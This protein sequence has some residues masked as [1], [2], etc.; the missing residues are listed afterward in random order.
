MAFELNIPSLVQK[1]KASLNGMKG[2]PNEL[3]ESED[4]F[5]RAFHFQRPFVP[6]WFRNIAYYMG[7]QWMDW[8]HNL[9][10]LTSPQAP[11]WK[12]RL[13]INLIMP[14]I[15]T[16]AAKILRNNP[17]IGVVPSNDS[18]MA[19]QA[20]RIG[21]RVMD[22]KYHDDD[23]QRK[24]YNLVLWMLTCGSAFLWTLWDKTAGKAWS[25]DIRN[26]EDGTIVKKQFFQ[27][28]VVDIVSGP[29]EVLMEPGA[30][31]DFEDHRRIMRI[32]VLDVVFIKDK[33][34]VD[35]PA[36]TIDQHLQFQFRINSFSH[37]NTFGLS[38][39]NTQ[40]LPRNVAL[41]KEIFELPSS[42]WPQGLHAMYANGVVIVPPEP[43]DYWLRGRRVLPVAKYDHITIPGRNYGMSVIEQISPL[44]ILFNKLNS[45]AVENANLLSRPKIIAPQGSLDDDSWT[46]QPGEVVEYRPV[47]GLGPSAMTPPSMPQY[48]FQL[49]DSIP[50]WI[51]DVSGIFDVSKGKLPRRATSG[52]AID[53]LQDADDTRMGLTIRNYASSLERSLGIKLQ[54]IKEN[55]VEERIVKKI[56]MNHGIEIMRFKGADLKDADTVRVMM[57]PALSR[58][59][60]INLGLKLAEQ[61]LV[62]KEMV[63]KIIELG[64]I[65]MIFDQDQDQTNFA[66]IE[67]FMMSKGDILEPQQF[68]PH[69]L[70]IKEHTDFLRKWEGKISK[71][72][73][74]VIQQHME[75]HK[76]MLVA[77]VP[78][79][80]PP[81]GGVPGLPPQGQ[82]GPVV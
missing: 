74:L 71:E 22:G 51:A 37:L 21:T 2:L 67:N 10:F 1:V 12:V 75:I 46:D 7:L 28:D 53:L 73:L 55:Y 80:G 17:S 43:L 63:L 42:K 9:Q 54:L 3:K 35:V 32:Q 77:M 20:A 38:H 62:P 81:D 82:P 14:T 68:E 34:G 60:K 19:R 59:A 5:A 79:G 26:P 76:E 64:D 23:F 78:P 36:E 61:N 30:P 66:K 16:E 40:S 65:N 29:F 8:N 45:Q 44:N 69:D 33:F 24:Q 58:A 6:I 13:V 47:G 27:G 41:V 48:F 39:A 52:K 49:K 56:G 11:S 31:E 57:T 18:D 15:R 25:E 72:I 4:F 50:G 70:H